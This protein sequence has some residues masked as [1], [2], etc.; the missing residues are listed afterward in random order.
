MTRQADVNG[1]LAANQA[2]TK[3]WHSRLVRATN[4]LTRLARQRQ[5]LQVQPQKRAVKTKEQAKPL[6]IHGDEAVAVAEAIMAR[7]DDLDI[8][9]TMLARSAEPQLIDRLKAK[10]PA[11]DKTKMPLSGREAENFLKAKSA[12]VTARRSKKKLA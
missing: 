8:R 4:A 9:S 10:R 11:I 7:K 6:G 1:K 3:R 12:E 2:A 5:R